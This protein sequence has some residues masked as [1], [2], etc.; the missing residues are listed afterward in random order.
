MFSRP[1]F[2]APSPRNA[3]NPPK[4]RYRACGLEIAFEAAAIP[5]RSYLRFQSCPRNPNPPDTDWLISEN[6]Q[7]STL[8]LFQPKRPK[9]RTS[10]ATDCSKLAPKPYLVVICSGWFAMFGRIVLPSRNWSFAT[11]YKPMLP[12][13]T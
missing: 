4:E 3:P 7:D 2:N 1:Y 8:P 5:P 13:L 6:D 9:A 11:S 10:F 12:L